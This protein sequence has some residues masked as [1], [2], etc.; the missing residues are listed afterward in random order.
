MKTAAGVAA[1][2]ALGLI[3]TYQSQDGA[4]LF[5]THM[6]TDDEIEFLKWQNDHGRSYGT[7]AEYK[8]REKIFLKNLKMVTEHNSRNDETFTMEMNHF[9]DIT[10][11]E[12]GKMMGYKQ[13]LRTHARVERELPTDNLAGDIDWTKEGAVTPVKNQGNCGSCWAFSTTGSIEGAMKIKGGS[14]TSLSEQQLLD[15]DHID[16]GCKGGIMENAYRYI[17]EK[18]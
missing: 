5:Q 1:L 16:K 14:L 13:E 12:Y 10:D 18:K 11:E 17:M 8:F 2:G 4:E 7:K 9:G 15:C 3:A 6:L